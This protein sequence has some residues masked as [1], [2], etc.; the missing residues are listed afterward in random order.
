MRNKRILI[1]GMAGSVGSELLKQ[2]APN[3]K[4]YGIDINET[5]IFDLIEEYQNEGCNVHGRVGDIRNEATVEEIFSDFKPQIVFHAAAYKHV[6]PMEWAPIE[7]IDT[8][9][10]GTYN[11]IKYTK[12][13]EADKFIFI[14]TDKAV[15]SGS[16]MGA[17]KRVCE[18]MVR[19]QGRGFV[20]V[21]FGNVLG[22]RGSVVPLWQKQVD[23]NKPITITDPHMERYMMT[24]DQAVNLVISA[25][26]MG[27]GGEIIILDMGERINVLELAKQVIKNSG[28][29][30]SI[31]EI[32]IRPGELLTEKLM[33]EEE[34]KVAIKKDNFYIIK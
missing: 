34:E 11:I 5:G 6:T 19:N 10:K 18:I 33:F 23:E 29:D 28:K 21:R 27:K 14:S 16:I 31:K 32:G 9:I 22:S 7:A 12:R 24:I 25:A 15:Q 30:I 26:E 17:T 20:V 8:N 3:N 2:L 13:Y 4:I 1:T